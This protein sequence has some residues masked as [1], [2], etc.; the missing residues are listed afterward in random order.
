MTRDIRLR[1]VQDS[2]LEVFHEQEQDPEAARRANFPPRER[3][4]FMNH[5]RTVVLGDPA[6]LIRAITVDG[7]LAGN[8]LSWWEEDR[9]FI[10]Y[11]LGREYWS[12]GVGTEALALF[13]QEEK[14]RPLYADPAAGNTA[15]VRLLRRHGFQDAGTVLHDGV[16]HLLLVLGES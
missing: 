8:V 11:W 7:R 14:I 12:K 1:P 13:L 2:D 15:S 10:G 3:T 6:N 16:E 5:W 9:R 4:R